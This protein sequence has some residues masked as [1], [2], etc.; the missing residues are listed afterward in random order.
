MVLVPEWGWYTNS[1]DTLQRQQSFQ[2][3]LVGRTIVVNP[4]LANP[5]PS[6]HAVGSRW[7]NPHRCLAQREEPGRLASCLTSK[8][9]IQP[10]IPRGRELFTRP[11]LAKPRGSGAGRLRNCATSRRASPCC[12]NAEDLR[13]ELPGG[14]H[15]ACRHLSGPTQDMLRSTSTGLSIQGVLCLV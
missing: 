1:R 6:P 13:K 2:G 11:P 7:I 8:L 15:L 14:L 9:T 12:N 10:E 3:F 4:S 5:V